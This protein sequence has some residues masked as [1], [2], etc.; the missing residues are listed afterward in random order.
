M[1]NDAN[2]IFY[3][4]RMTSFPHESFMY[5]RKQRERNTFGSL[6]TFQFNGVCFEKKNVKIQ[7]IAFE[8]ENIRRVFLKIN[9]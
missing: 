8:F 6:P 3:R 9:K 4:Q 2:R 5:I 7:A 1:K